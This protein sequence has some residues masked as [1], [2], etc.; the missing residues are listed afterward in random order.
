MLDQPVQYITLIPLM[1][2]H[3]PYFKESER[4]EGILMFHEEVPHNSQ[5]RHTKSFLTYLNRAVT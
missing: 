1:Y 2:L 4:P 5:I 3:T